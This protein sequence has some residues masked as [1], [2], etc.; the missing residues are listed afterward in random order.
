MKA[1]ISALLLLL[2]LLL[3]ST[4]YAQDTRI[5]YSFADIS[6]SGTTATCIVVIPG[7]TNSDQISATIKLRCGSQSIKTWNDSS[8]GVLSFKETVSVTKGKTYDL[9]VEYTINGKAQSSFSD[10]GTCK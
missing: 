7:N 1:R 4:A 3:T 10:S 9:V 6:F 2:L 5:N 8:S